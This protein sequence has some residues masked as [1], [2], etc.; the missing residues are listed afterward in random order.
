MEIQRIIHRQDNL[1]EEKVSRLTISNTQADSK[2]TIIK[3][4]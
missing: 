1:K 3:T 4:E 2:A